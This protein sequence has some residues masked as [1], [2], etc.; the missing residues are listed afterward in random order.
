MRGTDVESPSSGAMPALEICRV[1]RPCSR[2]DITPCR[3]SLPLQLRR[4][5][6]RKRTW[7]PSE[8]EMSGRMMGIAKEVRCARLSAGYS[9]GQKPTPPPSPPRPPMSR[10]ALQ[11]ALSLLLPLLAASASLRSSS[12][13]AGPAAVPS[14][15]PLLGGCATAVAAIAPGGLLPSSSSPARPSHRFQ[16]GALRSHVQ[17]WQNPGRS[18]LGIEDP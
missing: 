7:R 13:P 15:P 18:Q 4:P 10:P 11:S 5:G 6:F 16:G 14:L 8:V 9:G 3:H 12:S 2:M 17:P 1:S